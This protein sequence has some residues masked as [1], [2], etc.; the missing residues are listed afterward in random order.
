MTNTT[1]VVPFGPG[2]TSQ[3]E[4]S[5]AS[6]GFTGDVNRT[7]KYLRDS[8]WF[9]PTAETTARAA[10]PNVESPCKMTPPK[11]VALPTSGSRKAD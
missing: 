7:P 8:G 6:P 10:K 3:I 1:S 5:R 2:P 11:P 9:P 4:V